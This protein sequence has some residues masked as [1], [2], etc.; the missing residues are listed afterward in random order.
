MPVETKEWVCAVKVGTIWTEPNSAR[1]IDDPGI[2]NPV[3]LVEWLE[4]LPYKERLALCNENRVQTQILYGEPVLV[5][6][7]EGEWAKVVA[8]WQPS[9]KDSRGYPGWIPL[10]QIQPAEQVDFKGIARVSSAK[11]QLWDLQHNPLLVLPF[12]TILPIM[13]EDEVFYTVHTPHGKALLSKTHAQFAPSLEQLPK[14]FAE[15]AVALG[16]NYLDLPYLWGGMSPYGYDC[17]GFS[18]NMLKACGYIIPRDASDQA[19]TG[20]GISIQDP[21]L[22]KKGDLLF[23]ANDEGTGPVRHVGFYYGNGQLLH[24]HSTGKTVEILVLA[25]SKL[26]KEICAVRRYAV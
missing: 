24:S 23:F 8:I 26:E 6:T 10:S 19:K 20:E 15:E 21:S 22:W 18:Y 3:L 5:E 14:R 12:N 11:A 7:I 1:E 13:S 2:S 9:K 25:G 4:A 17:S 16:E